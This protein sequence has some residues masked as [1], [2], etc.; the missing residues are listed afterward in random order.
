MDFDWTHA[1]AQIGIIIV[2]YYV[3]LH[4]SPMRKMPRQRQFLFFGGILFL[5]LFL[6]NLLWP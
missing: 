6:F 2:V 4:F 1:F 5:V 3:L